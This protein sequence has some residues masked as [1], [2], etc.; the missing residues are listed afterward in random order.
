M[1]NFTR[2][3]ACVKQACASALPILGILTVISCAPKGYLSDT[4]SPN[5]DLKRIESVADSLAYAHL[6]ENFMPGMTVAVARNGEVV[7]SRGYGKADVEM[8][9]AA[10]TETVYPIASISKQFTAATIMRLVEKGK[11]SLEDSITKFLPNYPVQGHHVTVH[12]LLNH[13]SGIKSYTD[14]GEEAQQKLRQGLSYEEMLELFAKEPFD[15]K[16]GEHFRYNNSGYY[17]LGQ[18]IGKVTGIPYEAYVE[19]ELL[20]PLGLHHTL[21]GSPERI[22]PKRA[23]GYKYERSIDGKLLN[24]FPPHLKNNAAGGLYSTAGDLVRWTHLLHSGKV[25]SPESLQKMTT[26][27]ALSSGGTRTYGYGL[28]LAQ[29]GDHPK[30]VHVGDIDGFNSSLAFYPEDSLTV[31]VLANSDDTQHQEIEEFLARAALGME[32]PQVPDL[33]VTAEDMA[34]YEGTYLLEMGKRTAELQVLNVNGKLKVQ[35]GG[36]KAFRLRSQGNHAFIPVIDDEIR[37]VFMV[38]DKRAEG[39]VVHQGER[40][41]YGKKKL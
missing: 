19:E 9:V 26:P 38:K 20:Q 28:D 23:K 34:R 2:I 27:T 7:F 17:L 14:L 12:H 39:V 3:T 24:A 22:I 32:L 29:L 30:V 10:G 36:G 40:V 35:L 41:S 21:F 11:I 15:F 4:S 13:T 6:A 8:G 1:K 37:L 33:P 25:V 18:I 5:I 31:V 16:P